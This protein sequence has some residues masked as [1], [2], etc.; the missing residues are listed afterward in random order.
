MGFL[1][2][3]ARGFSAQIDL[4]SSQLTGCG[5]VMELGVDRSVDDPSLEA[6]VGVA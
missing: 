3:L 2:V 6:G 5:I 1:V 4:D